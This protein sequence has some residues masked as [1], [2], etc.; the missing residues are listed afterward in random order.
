L[1]PE[2]VPFVLLQGAEWVLIA[3]GDHSLSNHTDEAV[4]HMLH[5]VTKLD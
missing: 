2:C 3:G 4:Q 5:F 1:F